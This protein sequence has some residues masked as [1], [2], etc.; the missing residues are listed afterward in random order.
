VAR[1]DEPRLCQDRRYIE[2]VT[3]TEQIL[4]SVDRFQQRHTVPAFLVAVLKKFGDDSAGVLVSNLALSAF[5]AVFPLL[6][7]L[8]TVLGIVLEGNPKLEQS[9]LH[10]TF[11]QFPMIG[12][13]LSDNV[14]ALHRNSV[15][16][17]TVGLLGLLWGS[18]GMSRAALFAMA[19]VWN[20]PGPERPTY[21]KR[22]ARSV[23]FIGVL[24]LG[25]IV[26]T[27]LTAFGNFGNHNV[28]LVIVGEILAVITN[29]G[30]YILAF[31][32]LTP[33][34]IGTRDLVP[35][36]I[37]GG[38]AWTI[39]LALGG[40]LV[41]HY[42]RHADEVAGVFGTVLGLLA[43]LYLGS[44]LSIYAAELNPVIAR[45]L[46]PRSII[47]PPLTEADKRVLALQAEQN[48]RRP[49]QRVEVTFVD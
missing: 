32:V 37:A 15:L 16:G 8:V 39:L 17:L 43:W 36:A 49:E 28:W 33:K 42:L 26:S 10:S 20:L 45:H 46:W 4:R 22:L 47:Q 9:V 38:V 24:G 31:R 30:Q 12:T 48:Q 2:N 3:R 13:R 44:R 40:Y 1:I 29:I 27:F 41:G 25:L 14:H 21:L 6:L 34:V 18:L 11:A 23:I 35:G 19:Q 7:I 5:I